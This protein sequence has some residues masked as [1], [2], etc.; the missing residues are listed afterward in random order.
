MIALKQ[1]AKKKTV[2]YSKIYRKK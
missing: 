1:K 2:D